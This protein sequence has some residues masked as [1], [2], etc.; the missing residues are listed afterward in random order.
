[1]TDTT[2]KEYR[3]LALYKFVHP[4]LD[5]S[6][7]KELQ[8]DLDSH[9][10]KHEARGC[11]L[12]SEEGINGTICYPAGVT[13]PDPLL[14]HLQILF[15]NLRVR[16]SHATSNVF[17]RLKVKLKDQIV[18]MGDSN[19]D[20]TK[21]VGQYVSPRQWDSLLDDP[22][23]LVIDARNEYEVRLGSFP[24]SINPHTQNFSEF[25]AWMTNEQ[26]LKSLSSSTERK[27]KK[28]AM[29]CTGGIRCEKATA[30]AKQLYPQVPVYHLE[31]GILGYLE[32][33][34]SEESR[35]Q[36]ECYVFDQRVAV[37]HGLQ[38]TETFTSCYACRQPLSPAERKDPSFVEGI[39][40]PY[41]I[42]QN[43]KKQKQRFEE[44]QKQM[45]L[46]EKEGKAHIH[47]PKAYRSTK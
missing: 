26:H 14:A 41:C 8:E 2:N 15:P 33:V 1:M 6:Q 11:L 24:N 43:S 37:R 20:P 5:D 45:Q 32:S 12:L 18:T 46:A 3:I 36:G 19:V 47:D 10:R 4:K 7:L 21:G 28:V 9:C 44:R 38:P 40:C 34:P 30:L 29:F 13:T 16:V 27:K 35:F 22:D 17:H 39:S 23:C 31:G 25:P 42:G